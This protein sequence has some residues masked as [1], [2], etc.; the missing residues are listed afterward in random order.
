MSAWPRVVI[1]HDFMETYGG[2]ERITALIAEAFPDAPVV[3]ITGR[4]EVAERMGVS[5]RFVSLLEPR[6]WLLRNYRLLAPVFP[7]IVGRLRVPDADVIISSSYAFA[8]RLRSR[9]GA[10]RVCYSYS[11]LRFAW[12]MEDD[13]QATWARNAVARA[14]F[15][16]LAAYMRRSDRRSARTVD[17]YLVP[18]EFVGDQI[19]RY[20]GRGYETV[21]APVDCTVF[22]PAAVDPADYWLFCGRLIEPY[23]KVKILVEAFSRLGIKLVIAGDGPERQ[24]LERVAGPNIEFTGML[25]DAQ[26]VD[27]MQRCRAA[28]FPSQDDF[29]LIPIE[30]A[31]CGRPVLAFAGGGALDTVAPGITGDFFETQTAEAIETAVRAFDPDSYVPE[32]IREHALK[33]DAPRF[34]ERI[35]AAVGRAASGQSADPS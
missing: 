17:Q 30:V 9:D 21:G 14:G 34:Q 7:S 11:P 28:I 5:D 23:K 2:A 6:P 25:D 29:G 4:R 1:A 15:R 16:S 19:R 10:R 3:A 26:L 27:R 22:R 31:A 33:W 13:Y 32:A 20:Y 8:H 35:V 24:G 18:T 12:A